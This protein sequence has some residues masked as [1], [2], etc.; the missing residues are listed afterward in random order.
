MNR[1]HYQVLGVTPEAG[2]KE[3][4]RAYHRL[5]RK[6]HPDKATTPEEAKRLEVEFAPVSRAYNVLKDH[7]KRK[8]Y[9]ESLKRSEGSGASG[10]TQ[11]DVSVAE[12]PRASS[13]SQALSASPHRQNEAAMAARASIGRKAF[14][15]GMQLYNKG[16]YMKS[17][18]FF[19]A[20]IKNS[21]SEAVYYAKLAKAL[22]QAKR[23]FTRAR[24]MALKAI[25]L[26]PYNTEYR[27]VLGEICEMAGSH[28]LAV[29]AY[30]EVL[31]WDA[32]NTRALGRLAAL[33][34]ASGNNFLRRLLTRFKK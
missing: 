32:E 7:E 12:A 10:E 22:M 25:E 27:L 13:I 2:E 21:D 29:Q 26:D 17:T 16:E 31:R 34:G 28:S 30:K 15:M 14:A 18:E 4:K 1:T 19:E 9:D 24:E 33:E 11:S 6:M 5:A 3:I 20:A 8:E 23:S